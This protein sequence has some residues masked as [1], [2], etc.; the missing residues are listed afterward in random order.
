MK[1]VKY[2]LAASALILSVSSYAGDD[3]NFYYSDG[4]QS[5]SYSKDSG[6]SRECCRHLPP[7]RHFHK[8]RH[9]AKHHHHYHPH[10]PHE[11]RYI[12]EEHHHYY[13][14]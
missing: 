14:D 12:I 13:D 10:H 4:N 7:P 11:P 1:I 9:Y 2:V 3:V 6:S 8:H 5:F